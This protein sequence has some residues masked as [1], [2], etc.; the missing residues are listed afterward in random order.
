VG[1]QVVRYS[2]RPELWEGTGGLFA[3]IWPEYN[4]H[5]QVLNC[6]WDRLYGVRVVSP[7][8]RADGAATDGT[9]T[10]GAVP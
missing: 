6:Y 7:A 4:L 1:P 3:D 10:A 5:G 8:F 2:E 9:A